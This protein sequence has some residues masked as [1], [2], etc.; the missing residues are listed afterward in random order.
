[1]QC[2]EAKQN[3]ACG[4]VENAKRFERKAVAKNYRYCLIDKKYQQNRI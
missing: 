2:D 3:S 1:M 4:L